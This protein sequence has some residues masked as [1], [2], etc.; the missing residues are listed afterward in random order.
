M[1]NASWIECSG[2]T[3]TFSRFQVLP[4]FSVLNRL[5]LPPHAKPRSLL[6]NL[7]DVSRVM[8]PSWRSPTGLVA[9][10]SHEQLKEAAAP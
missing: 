7:R 10:P 9:A 5:P 6:R 1:R 3:R 8:S 2:E 4:P